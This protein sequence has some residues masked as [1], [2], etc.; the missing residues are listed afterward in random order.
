MSRCLI[1]VSAN[2][3]LVVVIAAACAESPMNRHRKAADQAPPAAEV[4]CGTRLLGSCVSWRWTE[5]PHSN[6]TQGPFEEPPRRESRLDLQIDPPLAG[7]MRASLWMPSMSH[8]G[9]GTPT[10]LPMSDGRFRLR[11]LVFTMAGDW[12]V[13]LEW[14][15]EGRV[16][17]RTEIEIYLP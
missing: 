7:E 4:L 16:V 8:G 9:H 5:G 15:R 17:G 10:V 1:E 13:R 14:W 6:Q 3:M 11:N 2:L 12:Q